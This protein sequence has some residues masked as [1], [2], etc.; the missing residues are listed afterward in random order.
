MM[1]DLT[2]PIPD[3]DSRP[4]WAALAQGRLEV[5]QCHDCGRLSWPARPLC[6]KCHGERLFWREVS[7]R[8]A[9]YSWVVAH[10]PFVPRLAGEVPYVVALV[11]LEEDDGVLI[12]GALL[13]GAG[14][15]QG[16]RVQATTRPLTDDVGDLIWNPI[17]SD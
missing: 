6:S 14:V 2:I 4:Y 1:D 5:Q 16:M 15:H 7:G 10:R 8:G 17:P 3:R 9:V 13:P 12:P 11:R